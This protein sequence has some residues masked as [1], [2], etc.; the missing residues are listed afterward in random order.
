MPPFRQ[1]LLAHLPALGDLMVGLTML[2]VAI[3]LVDL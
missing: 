2:V 1:L 3:G